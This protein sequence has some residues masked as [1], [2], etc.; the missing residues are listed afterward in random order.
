MGRQ[1]SLDGCGE[2]YTAYASF[3]LRANTLKYLPMI[4]LSTSSNAWVGRFRYEKVE[5]IGITQYSL[6]LNS[7]TILVAAQ[8]WVLIQFVGEFNTAGNFLDISY[9][10]GRLRNETPNE[11]PSSDLFGDCFT[12]TE[13]LSNNAVMFALL[14]NC[15]MSKTASLAL[16][17]S[18]RTSLNSRANIASIQDISVYSSEIFI[19]EWI[20]GQIYD[21]RIT[22]LIAGDL[23]FDIKT[24]TT[25]GTS[26]KTSTTNPNRIR[27]KIFQAD[28]PSR[29]IILSVWSIT[30][31]YLYVTNDIMSID[32]FSGKYTHGGTTINLFTL[33]IKIVNI[34][35]LSA[36]FEIY[37][38]YPTQSSGDDITILSQTCIVD[39]TTPKFVLKLSLRPSIVGVLQYQSQGSGILPFEV[40]LMIVKEVGASMPY[41][42]PSCITRISSEVILA[43]IPTVDD[44][45]YFDY[46]ETSTT[47]S[48]LRMQNLYIY[49]G[50][51]TLNL[52]EDDLTIVSS[53]AHTDSFAIN[54]FTGGCNLKDP[55]SGKCYSCI[56][57]GFYWDK[58]SMKCLG[59]QNTNTCS[60]CMRANQCEDCLSTNT[61]PDKFRHGN[62][63]YA[64]D[65]NCPHQNGSYGYMK[66]STGAL[67]RCESCPLNAKECHQG[68]WINKCSDY[69]T[70]SLLVSQEPIC[71]CIVD[72]CELCF[73]EKCEVCDLGYRLHKKSDGSASCELLSDL[74]ALS[75]NCATHSPIPHYNNSLLLYCFEGYCNIGFKKTGNYC[76]ACTSP[77]EGYCDAQTTAIIIANE[78][79][80]YELIPDANPGFFNVATKNVP[81]PNTSFLGCLNVNATNDCVSCQSG[82]TLGREGYNKMGCKCPFGQ[83]KDPI[84]GCSFCKDG[85]KIIS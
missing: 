54:E 47:N 72:H 83:Y 45:V 35:I 69:S 70:L 17:N 53:K 15:E 38:E 75:L 59:C 39:S 56:Q 5:T 4:E 85:C 76:E 63:I 11:I 29:S 14:A 71:K 37:K 18:A 23:G 65:Q 41:P 74:T 21:W 52:L 60:I 20:T 51:M 49:N 28:S 27:S 40:E 68:V 12:K 73:N 42:V 48:Y 82:Y 10:R 1:L 58:N 81:L 61:L 2:D 33:R 67:L 13:D 16:L 46:A 9:Y 57:D 64:G 55:V 36:R 78:L 8:S 44:E 43:S 32:D 79:Q 7:N 31:H 24:S 84:K 26:M 19:T 25:I 34:D 80:S 66:S 30:K 6:S 3:W 50:G 62:C 77:I 22:S